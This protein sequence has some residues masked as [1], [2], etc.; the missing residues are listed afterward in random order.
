MIYDIHICKANEKKELQRFIDTHW[1]KGHALSKSAQLLDFMHY[2][3]I[4]NQYNFIVARNTVT[5]ELDGMFGFIPYMQYDSNMTIDVAY[6]GVMWK[7]RDDVKNEEIGILGTMLWRKITK[8]PGF[9]YYYTAGISDVAKQFY[10]IARLRIGVLK[11]YYLLNESVDKFKIAK[12]PAEHKI[13]QSKVDQ[14]VEIKEVSASDLEGLDYG[15]TPNKSV[16]FV[17]N[18][19]INHPIYKYTIY[20]VFVDAELKYGLICRKIETQGSFCLRVVD[21]YGCISSSPNI[22]IQLQELLSKLSCEYI[23]CLNYGIDNK[24]FNNMGF[25]LLDPHQNE[26]II[27]N[28]FEPF[29]QSNIVIECAHS[30]SDEFVIFKGDGDQDRPNMI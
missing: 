10:T 4:N 15:Y 14:R 8:L 22:S 29:E 24:L 27:P 5:G 1:S 17:I 6:F 3:S 2:D 13:P 25:S 28:Y 9:K 7:V 16:D 19:Y 11:Q 21:I 12:V 26:I 30:Q 18:R 20:G 23:D